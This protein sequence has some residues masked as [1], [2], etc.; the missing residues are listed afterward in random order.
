MCVLRAKNVLACQRALHAYVLTCQRALRAYV[1][2]CQCAMRAYVLTSQRALR[3]YVPYVLTCQNA[4]CAYVLV[5]KCAIL[6]NVNLYI[7]QI[8]NYIYKSRQYSKY[9]T[10]NPYKTRLAK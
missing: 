8:L 5:C 10:L 9:S 2:T 1:L 6:N 4:L 7:I 3:A